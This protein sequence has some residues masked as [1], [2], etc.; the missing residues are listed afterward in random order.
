MGR[1]CALTIFAALAVAG[2]GRAQSP[3]PVPIHPPTAL[4]LAHAQIRDIQMAAERV[5]VAAADL[6]RARSRWLPTLYVGADY[7]FHDGRLQDI[8]GHVFST[9]RESAMFGLG[10]SL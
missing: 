4:H 1:R 2:P 10:P 8:V 7:A 6:D 9:R 5:S 3:Q